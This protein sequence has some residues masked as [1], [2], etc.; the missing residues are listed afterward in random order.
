MMVLAHIIKQQP[1][2]G[3]HWGP[4]WPC[5][6]S[7]SPY[8][9]P[10]ENSTV[11]PILQRGILRPREVQATCQ[12]PTYRKSWARDLDPGQWGPWAHILIHHAVSFKGSSIYKNM[13]DLC[14]RTLSTCN[15]WLLLGALSFSYAKSLVSWIGMLLK[16][17]SHVSIWVSISFISCSSPLTSCFYSLPT[18]TPL[19]FLGASWSF[20]HSGVCELAAWW[21]VSSL[22][23]CLVWHM[24]C[25]LT[26]CFLK[27]LN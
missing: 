4:C 15:L 26:E 20:T 2:S 9:T 6:A 11:I 23:I 12:N 16:K 27:F 1:Q 22:Q 17:F 14:S 10:C 19:A 21:A 13:V 18:V 7:F 5:I 3:R 24:Q 25:W 8:H